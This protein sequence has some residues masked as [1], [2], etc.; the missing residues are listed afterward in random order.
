MLPLII[1]D[2]IV[3]VH[4]TLP[5]LFKSEAYKCLQVYLTTLFLIPLRSKYRSES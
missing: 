5:M 4:D 2:V 3:N 1:F